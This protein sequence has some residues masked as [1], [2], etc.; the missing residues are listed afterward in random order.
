MKDNYPIGATL[1]PS[2]PYNQSDP[3]PVEVDCCVSYSLSKSMPVK[4]Q[5]YSVSEEYESD[6]DDD[7]HKYCHKL[8]EN[9]FDDTNFIEEFKND[10]AAIGIP[11][12]LKEL[13]KLVK[14]RVKELIDKFNLTKSYNLRQ[15]IRKQINHYESIL[16]ATK[17]WT[18]DELDVCQE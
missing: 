2:A 11:T 13:Q 14:E 12:L 1:D 17:D 3:E 16:Q 10:N 15:K 7:G 18:I 9:N 5:N 8:Q 4:V 6:I